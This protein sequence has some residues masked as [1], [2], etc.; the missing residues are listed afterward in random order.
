MSAPVVSVCMPVRDAAATLTEALDSVL[1]QTFTELEL[2]VVDDG[3]RDQTPAIL[4]ARAAQDDRIRLL[5][6]SGSGVAA[7]LRQACSAATGRYVARM[8]ADDVSLPDRLDR[9]VAYLDRHARTAVVGGAYIVLRRS[10]RPGRTVRMPTSDTAIKL[11]L[12]RWNPIAHPTVAMRR[13]AYEQVG[14][15]RLA[16]AEDYDLWTR[17]AERWLLANLREPVLLR[18]EHAAQVSTRSLDR[19]VIAVLAAAAAARTRAA[20]RPDPLEGVL[21]PT[22]ELL[23]QLGVGPERLQTAVVAACLSRAAAL[24]DAG[25]AAAAR[26]LLH[27]AIELAPER[28]WRL[29]AGFA[30][31][32]VHSLVGR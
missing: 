16:R 9:Q 20:G 17:L 15:Y 26:D 14:G 7:A 10:A 13:D 27:R 23:E 4:S 21:E 3:S 11:A 19:D 31:R 30:L 8:D 24:A 5:A 28:A 25:S 2:I 29:R 6:A 18:R 1:Q 32:R 22:R 12:P